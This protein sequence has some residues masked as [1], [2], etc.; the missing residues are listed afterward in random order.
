M[1][2]VLLFGAAILL[3]LAGLG[4]LA[5][6]FHR[7]SF[8]LALGAAHPLL[9]WLAALAMLLLL[10][11]FARINVSTLIVVLLHLAVAFMLCALLALL[12]QTFTGRAI[13]YDWRAL[14]ALLLTAV[15]L[16][17]GWY[18]A[19]HVWEKDYCL[20]T[21]KAAEPLRIALIADSHLGIT[22]DGDAFRREMERIQATE[23]DLLVLAGDFVDDD[24]C[25]A[26]MLEAC[27]ALGDM[28][29]RYGVYYIYGNHDEGYFNSRDFNGR[30]LR[31]ALEENG[32]V[33][34]TDQSV[35]IGEGYTLL[36]RL[37]RSDPERMS[38]EEL[39]EG[40]DRGRYTIVLDHQPN[41]YAAE[42]ASGVDLVL[43]GHTHGGHMF[44]AG[45]LGLLMHANDFNYGITSRG[46]TTFIVTS[47]ISGWAIPFKTGTRSE[48]VSI[49]ISGAAA[50]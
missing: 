13:P 48:F 22:L 46:K 41:D 23:P 43:S 44:P 1:M 2:W 49:D 27:R 15:Y 31:Q 38:M 17:C 50:D 26:D 10:G 42:A 29:T 4:Y 28:T 5:V 33:I 36:G 45:Q 37:D 24:S 12:F 16:G 11:L 39:T 6:C 8:V 19:H 3:A 47:G 20:Q 40:L 25:R 35:P 14:C 7:F 21:D 9:S 18:N 34:L 30:E 32:V